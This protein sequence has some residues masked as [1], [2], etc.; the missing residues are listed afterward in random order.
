MK[1]LLM[2]LTVLTSLAISGN[3]VI[4]LLA[5]N[6]SNNMLNQK[7]I[8]NIDEAQDISDVLTNL[9]LGF[10][11]TGGVNP[12]ETQVKNYIS[13]VNIAYVSV[14]GITSSTAVVTGNNPLYYGSVKIS[15]AIV[16]LVDLSEILT[17]TDLGNIFTAE[18]KPVANQI[19]TALK[20]DGINPD[21]DVNAV[22]VQNIT[23]TS[24]TIVGDELKYTGTINVTFTLKRVEDIMNWSYGPIR[25][26]TVNSNGIFVGTNDSQYN[27]NVYAATETSNTSGKV[28]VSDGIS[29]FGI[30]PGIPRDSFAKYTVPRNLSI[31]NHG[32]VYVVV[33]YTNLG[34][35]YAEVYKSLGTTGFRIVGRD[36]GDGEGMSVAVDNNGTIFVGTRTESGK[37]ELYKYMTG[38][39]NFKRVAVTGRIKYTYRY[40]QWEKYIFNC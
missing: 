35:A 1:K 38:D 20:N 14:N 34:F 12:S 37:G 6:T 18:S 9:N 16:Q 29:S 11:E 5:Q 24:A 8:T 22:V 30:L 23:A 26:V 33:K 3:S 13:S 31:D 40:F 25:A 17:T 10:I 7:S 15:F 32:Y 28:Y 39:T 27:G 2:N 4:P 19:K 21:L 36:F